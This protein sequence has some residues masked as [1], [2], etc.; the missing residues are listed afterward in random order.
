MSNDGKV[1]HL[2][3]GLAIS[4]ESMAGGKNNLSIHFIQDIK[5]RFKYLELQ[6]CS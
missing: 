2:E 4:D 5:Q 3:Q 6:L 1:K